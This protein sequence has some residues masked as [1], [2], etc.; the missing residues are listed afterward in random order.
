MELA[1]A[2]MELQSKDG[3]VDNLLSRIFLQQ[4]HAGMQQDVKEVLKWYLENM[5]REV[6]KYPSLF[7]VKYIAHFKLLSHKWCLI[8]Q[9]SNCQVTTVHRESHF[10]I[11]LAIGNQPIQTRLNNAIVVT[12]VVDATCGCCGKA[13]QHKHITELA[14]APQMIFIVN[15]PQSDVDRNNC[16]S[17][18]IPDMVNLKGER[19]DLHSCIYHHEVNFNNGH[20]TCHIKHGNTW[21][22]IDDLQLTQQPINTIPQH[23]YLLIYFKINNTGDT[24]EVPSDYQILDK[25]RTIITTQATQTAVWFRCQH[26]RSTHTIKEKKPFDG[27]ETLRRHEQLCTRKPSQ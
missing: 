10:F 14:T 3:C 18:T 1:N 4:Y 9:C 12:E 23:P 7:V 11:S 20:Y 6:E 21:Y 16:L 13:C 24:V 2:T 19:Y 25:L 26:C 22:Y 15:P 27:V 8:T 17:T 5:R